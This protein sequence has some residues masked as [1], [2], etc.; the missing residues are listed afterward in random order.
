M[1]RLALLSATL[2]LALSAC[3]TMKA[4]A[5]PQ[6]L[7][8]YGLDTQGRLVTFGT[9]N[10]TQSLKRT[11][12]T[13]LGSSETL[14]D[15]DVRN[16]DNRLYAM[17]DTG[18]LYRLD[19]ATGALTAD[20]SSLTA[21]ITPV[22]I[23]FNP[24]ANRLRVL[25]ETDRNFRLTLNAAP[26]PTAS[27]AG[28][29]TDDGMLMYVGGTPNPNLV[30]AAYT[31]SFNN[32]AAGAINAGTMTTLYSV[33]ADQDTLVIHSVGPQFSTL[34]PVGKLGVDAMKGMTGFDIAGAD[35]AY[36]S[37]SMGGNTMLYTV[38]LTTGAATSRSTVSGLA[39][40]SFALALP[41]Q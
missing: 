20:G 8:A 23:D 4:P 16:T 39:L 21:G 38:N 27:P 36:L 13:G 30:A 33:D 34:A 19:P 9:D 25:A 32:S 22:A 40:R 3:G 31:N 37:V 10:A 15:L 14:I 28:T 35:M 11:A 2:A 12:V 18:K 26:V 29:V 5:A 41:N 17:S 6:G 7:T 24:A 1:K